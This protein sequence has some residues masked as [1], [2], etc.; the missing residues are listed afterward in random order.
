MLVCSKEA[1]NSK[2]DLKDDDPEIVGYLLDYMYRGNYDV[3]CDPSGY[4]WLQ[5]DWSSEKMKHIDQ[6]NRYKY[7]YFF[8]EI[9]REVPELV[10]S[11]LLMVASEVS[12][13]SKARK[14]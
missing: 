3:A 12:W 14:T 10:K 4:H 13:K 5:F 7:D 9:S 1:A 11:H 8:Y 6:S 2:I